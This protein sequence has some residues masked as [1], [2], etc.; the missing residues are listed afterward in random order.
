LERWSDHV[1]GQRRLNGPMVTGG[2]N[3]TAATVS[4]GLLTAAADGVLG[5]HYVSARSPRGR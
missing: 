3:V 5:G 2:T 4:S 1:Y